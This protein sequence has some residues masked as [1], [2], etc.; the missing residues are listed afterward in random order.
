MQLFRLMLEASTLYQYR[1]FL[2]KQT[3]FVSGLPVSSYIRGSVAVY[4]SWRLDSTLKT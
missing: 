3:V 1:C 4:L 2:H